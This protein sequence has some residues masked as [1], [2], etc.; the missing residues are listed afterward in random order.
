VILDHHG[1]PFERPKPIA[2]RYDAA[3]LSDENR[4]HW[5]E[6]DAL[7]ARAANAPEVRARLRN[8]CRYEVANN[9]W[10]EGVANALADF[11][12]GAGPTLQVLT[13]DR[14]F[15]RLVESEFCDW[16]EAVDLSAKLWRLRR[17]RAVDGEGFL[18]FDDDPGL[19][20][21]TFDLAEFE[22]DQVATPTINP[23]TPLMVDGI[24]LN[25]ARKPAFYHLLKEHPGDVFWT[26]F[27]AQYERIPA[28]NVI[29]WFR[30]TRPGQY[31]GI[32]EFT[33]SLGLFANLR[34]YRDA[35]ISAAETA[36]N[37]AAVLYTE[38]PPDTEADVE[39]SNWE[40]IPI[41]RRMLT[42][43][44][45]GWKMAQFKP[46]QPTT[47]HPDFVRTC[48]T[49]LATGHSITYEIASGDYSNVNY[50]SGRLGLQR[51]Q[52]AIE[53]DRARMESAC[54]NRILREW[55]REASAVR[56]IPNS[57]ARADGWAHRWLWPGIPSID[58]VK[59]AT[60]AQTRLST[61][62]TTFSEECYRDGVD[63]ETRADEI[64]R[65]VEMFRE[66]GLPSPYQ[67]SKP[68][69]PAGAGSANDGQDSG[70]ANQ[71]GGQARGEQTFVHRNGHLRH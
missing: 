54:L 62:T 23:L 64:A 6:S 42:T 51:F 37:F 40:K 7:S 48:L 4:R 45:A 29:H 43:V 33:A 44:P 58:P 49:E 24:E 18:F 67:T 53:V 66:R 21:V 71:G 31:R 35:T 32:P 38:Q 8:R 28:A 61:F 16:C 13:A 26:S 20:P 55:L 25:A 69:A 34:R 63:P 15:N 9:S 60:A 50:S 19:G 17:V 2:A 27:P 22:A 39:P 56:L 36:A 59:D 5:A 10:A 52:R 12:V 46:E 11:M 47:G 41:D 65:D 1:R 3:Q 57:I 30:A 68:A 14:T 70:D